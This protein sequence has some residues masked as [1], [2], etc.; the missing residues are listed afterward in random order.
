MNNKW[1]VIGIVAIAIVALG[2][3]FVLNMNKSTTN[4][5]NENVN[6]TTSPVSEST[7]TPSAM[8]GTEITIEGGEFKFTPSEISVKKGEKVKLTF[9]NAGKFSHDYVI[10][11][12]NVST[13]RI[14]PGEQDTIEF[15]PD[16]TGVFQFICSVG[17]HEEQGM[18]GTLI[19]E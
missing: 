15:T 7:T 5:P 2:G 1:I 18:V 12:L 3:F 13:K 9:K 16:K 14:Q 11:D 17:N 8:S 6:P 10:A 19:V 4:T